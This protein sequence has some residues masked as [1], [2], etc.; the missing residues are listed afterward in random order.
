[1]I[2]ISLEKTLMH[3]FIESWDAHKYSVFH[4][5]IKQRHCKFAKPKANN[6]ENRMFDNMSI[7]YKENTVAT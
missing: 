5:G 4:W 6:S 7:L 2:F 3:L 1:M